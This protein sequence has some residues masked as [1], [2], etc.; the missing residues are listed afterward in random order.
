MLPKSSFGQAINYCLSQWDKLIVFLQD[1]LLELDNNRSELSIKPFVIGRKNW[2][3]ANTQRGARASAITYSIIK[4]AKENGLKPCGI[5]C[6]KHAGPLTIGELAEVL[7]I[8]SSSATTATKRLAKMGL[9]KRDRQKEDER[10]V[11]VALISTGQE[12]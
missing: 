4:T 6:L 2:L 9:V 7:G 10:V 1:G 8:T 5:I 11:T 12:M 3:F